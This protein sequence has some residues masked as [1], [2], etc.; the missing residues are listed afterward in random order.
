MPFKVGQIALGNCDE[1]P[2][3]VL[4]ESKFPEK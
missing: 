2:N 4:P 3:P 1:G